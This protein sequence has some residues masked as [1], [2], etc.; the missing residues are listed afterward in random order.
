M[1]EEHDEELGQLFAAARPGLRAGWEKRAM[2]VI[3]GGRPVR[4]RRWSRRWIA[5]AVAAAAVMIGLGV[6]GI[7][8]GRQGPEWNHVLAAVTSASSI[9]VRARLVT[10]AGE[11]I[12]ESWLADGF[13]RGETWQ[14][15]DLVSLNMQSDSPGRPHLYYN[16]R[17]GKK[18]GIDSDRPPR[19]PTNWAALG[20]FGAGGDELMRTLVRLAGSRGVRT[21]RVARADRRG[22]VEVI[23]ADVVLNEEWGWSLS[24]SAHA[25]DRLRVRAEMDRQ[26]DRLLSL[27][28][29]KL[30]GD[31]WEPTYVTDR[32]EYDVPITDGLKSFVFPHGTTVE[33][34]RWWRTRTDKV[35]VEKKVDA[36]TV[37]VHALDVDLNGDVYLT[38]S[39]RSD[40]ARDAS[41][42]PSAEAVDNRQTRYGRFQGNTVLND[43]G[44]IV[45]RP[46]VELRPKGWKPPT[47][48]TVTF[49]PRSDEEPVVFRALPL[50]P[51]SEVVYQREVTY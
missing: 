20:T 7:P 43:Y 24:G 34:S 10:P 1:G 23:E 27:A 17:N 4:A 37:K 46:E 8:V 49:W 31:R 26:T 12:V 14:D 44:I 19:L 21:R 5:V 28:E 2:A 11:K 42:C 9:H 33:Y 15:G 18:R 16:V 39:L 47:E 35:I 29:Y 22:Q 13:H 50:P 41:G 36:W 30:E 3:E 38:F 25:G 6:V 32:I 51:P 45:M 48:I 40:R